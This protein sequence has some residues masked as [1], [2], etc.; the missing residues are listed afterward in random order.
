MNTNYVAPFLSYSIN[1][2]WQSTLFAALAWLLIVTLLRNNRP[3]SR[4]A[5]WLAASIKFL[6]PFAALIDLGGRLGWMKFAAPKTQVGLYYAMDQISRRAAPQFVPSALRPTVPAPGSPLP[7]LLLIVW[8][9]GVVVVA[10][11]WWISWRRVRQAVDGATPLRIF[12]GIPVL[13]S[14]ALRERGLEP[15]VF[16][17]RRAVVLV[18][19]GITERLSP[20]QFDAV[21][22]HECCHARRRDNLAAAIHMSVEALFWFHPLVWWL[23]HRMMEE[24]ERACDEEVL[25]RTSDPEVYAEGIL[26]VCKFYLE[27]PLVCVAGI[28]G[29]NLKL[30][31]AE[32]MTHRIARELGWARTALLAVAGGASIFGPISI[33]LLRT[34]VTHAQTMSSFT[35]I[36][37]SAAKQFEVATVKESRSGEQRWRLG[38]PAHGSVSIDNLQLHRII[39][40]SFRIQ[41]SMVFGPAWL[42][43]TRYDIVGKGPDPKAANPEVW[44][45]MRVLLAERFQMKYHIETRQL[46][47]YALVVAKGGPK[48]LR[49]EDGPCAAKIQAGE[50]CGDIGPIAPFAVGIVNMPIGALIG[51][52]GRS[53]QDR[54]IVDKTG[55]TGKYDGRVLWMPD[56]MKPEDLAN[57]P[58]ELRPEDVSLFTAM[59]QQLG[60]KLEAQ[61][62]PVQVVVVDTIEKPAEN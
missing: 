55:L 47:I 11:K 52:L 39:A 49:P 5:V 34:P 17:L 9:C 53:I 7:T 42:D 56:N 32:I 50:N 36:Q 22:A 2:L 37:T 62:G 54:P 35:G 58:A 59:E 45:M 25:R 51:G 4:Y 28:T 3:Q 21:L 18:P 26:N 10:I 8:G 27:S 40:S 13:S 57:I 33:G 41:D 12:D 16:G 38:P 20:E 46:P 44:E 61:K 6:V 48:L 23:G 24:R 43:S 31:I 14:P 29:S 19:D 60:L 30:R 1:H 15:G